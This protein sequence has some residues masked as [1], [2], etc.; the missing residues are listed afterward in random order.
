MECAESAHRLFSGS[1]VQV[2]KPLDEPLLGGI[3]GIE[4]ILGWGVTVIAE[5]HFPISHLYS[6]PYVIDPYTYFDDV[7]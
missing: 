3:L 2:S 4:S 7:M 5:L 1:S 6:A